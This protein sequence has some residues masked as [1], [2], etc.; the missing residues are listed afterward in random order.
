[1]AKKKVLT[2]DLI[3]KGNFYYTKF[4]ITVT[5]TYNSAGTYIDA[6]SVKID[7]PASSANNQIYW[8]TN[9][10]YVAVTTNQNTT[11]YGASSGWFKKFTK[12]SSVSYIIESASSLASLKDDGSGLSVEVY[13]TGTNAF[14]SS[15][16]NVKIVTSGSSTS[17]ENGTE[18][19][20]GIDSNYDLTKLT[21]AN[22]YIYKS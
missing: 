3:R 14:P 19:Y 1:M 9:S 4:P 2:G 12:G 17:G 5:A 22:V 7:N 20:S 18:N 11:G 10:C 13:N 21:Q 6:I 8:D 16:T 15:I